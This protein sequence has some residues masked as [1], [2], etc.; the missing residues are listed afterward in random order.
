MKALIID[1]EAGIRLSLS[2]FLKERGY[3]TLEAVSGGEGLAAARSSFPDVIFL[4]KKLPDCDGESLL[5]SLVSSESGTSVIM[6]TAYVELDEAVKAMKQGAEYFFAK[7]FDLNQLS[8]VL[9]SIE[10]RYRLRNE[11]LHCR[12]LNGHTA[13]SGMVGV[14]PQINRIQRLVSLLARNSTTP[15]L[16]LGESGSGKEL[17]ASAIHQQGMSTGPFVEINSASLSETLLESELFGHE[18][19]AFTDASKMK[20]GL[21]EIANNGTIFFDELAEMP[22]AIQAKLLKVLDSKLFRRVGGVADIRSNARFVGATNKDLGALV[23]RG[24]FREDLFYRIN[25]LP[26][27]IPPLR[28]RGR[29]IVLLA[30]HFIRHLGEAMGKAR[31]RASS[32][33]MQ[34]LTRHHWPGN[35]RELKN[36]I[37]R[38]LILAE[39]HELS[40]DHLPVELRVNNPVPEGKINAA[41]FPTLQMLEDQHIRAALRFTGGNHSRTASILGISRST[42]LVKL[43]AIQ[44]AVQ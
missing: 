26:I 30:E 31:V 8:L 41:E 12:N 16:I 6:M 37:E 27:T 21:F 18:K 42:L 2:H 36:I 28:E 1:D 4:D 35:V 20:K 34:A 33:F 29:D 32:E 10:E 3:E 22:L 7:P 38:A 44:S 17:V 23:K 5:S 14:S 40:P 9:D 15:V 24:L 11:L 39:S 19:G 25:V 43:K 13:A